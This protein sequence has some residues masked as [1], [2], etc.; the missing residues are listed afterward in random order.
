M[1]EILFLPYSFYLLAWFLLV[2]FFCCSP[3]GWK[4]EIKEETFF[5][6]F[7]MIDCSQA[8]GS[9][10]YD[11]YSELIHLIWFS[12]RSA[13]NTQNHMLQFVS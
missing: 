8:L 2:F 12:A 13:F 11:S 4:D 6:Q 7:P 1:N 10:K 5:L 3:K 9:W